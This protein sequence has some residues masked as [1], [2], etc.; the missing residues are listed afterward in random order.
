[1]DKKTINSNSLTTGCTNSSLIDYNSLTTNYDTLS[2]MRNDYL[3][4]KEL[5]ESRL[6]TNSRNKTK[7]T[8]RKKKVVK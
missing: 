7:K 3:K 4:Y 2:Q 5:L 8:T 1:M 6:K